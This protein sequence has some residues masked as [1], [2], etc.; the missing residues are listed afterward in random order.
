ML[1]DAGLKSILIN[2]FGGITR[3]DD[4]ANGILQAKDKFEKIKSGEIPLIVR[5]MGTNVK[6]GIGILKNAG[7][8]AFEDMEPAI[9]QAVKEAKK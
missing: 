5:I 2:A 7:I 9:E 1:K 3:M 4:V 6:E 8:T